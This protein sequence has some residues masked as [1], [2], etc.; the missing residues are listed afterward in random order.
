MSFL[1]RNNDGTAW[2]GD[3]LYNWENLYRYNLDIRIPEGNML[4][5][6]DAYSI[7]GVCPPLEVFPPLC[8]KYGQTGDVILFLHGHTL[9]EL[10][11]P[12][13]QEQNASAFAINK[14]LYEPTDWRIQVVKIMEWNY[15]C[16]SFYTFLISDC[17]VKSQAWKT[18]CTILQLLK[19]SP[20]VLRMLLSQEGRPCDESACAAFW[21]TVRSSLRIK[22][23]EVMQSESCYIAF[24][25]YCA[26]RKYSFFGDDSSFAFEFQKKL[27]E[28]A[29]VRLDGVAKNK[30]PSSPESFDL[31]KVF[32]FQEFI[33][34]FPSTLL[35]Q[36]IIDVS[37][38]SMLSYGDNYCLHSNYL[39][40][41]KFYASAIKY[42]YTESEK[43]QIRQK[44]LAI[45]SV[46]AIA[47]QQQEKERQEREQHDLQS[48][49][50][51]EIHDK[52]ESV[53]VVVFIIGI[54]SAIA[55][56]SLLIAGVDSPVVKIIFWNGALFSAVTFIIE[57]VL[58]KRHCSKE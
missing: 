51:Q 40:A 42:A 39:K 37:L 9:D 41:D 13:E 28:I 25:N 6:E 21:D 23:K 12:K 36:R 34:V 35:K 54:V 26:I 15:F 43:E 14:Y 31:E 24:S 7:Y 3:I 20:E 58:R 52:V 4:S 5:L 47:R 8:K 11:I 45:A 53:I 48:A 17:D 10:M 33:K 2:D 29:C 16:L 1:I 22:L 50:R 56:G 27:E 38:S 57:F 32:F 46:V 30:I 18:I 49:R 55:C 19:N 44:R